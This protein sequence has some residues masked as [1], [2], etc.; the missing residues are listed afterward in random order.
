MRAP[1]WE[2]SEEELQ[3][4][5]ESSI[6]RSRRPSVGELHLRTVLRSEYG[7]GGWRAILDGHLHKAM[8]KLNP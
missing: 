1:E 6:T 7:G 3:E 4:L 8:A 5:V 2:L